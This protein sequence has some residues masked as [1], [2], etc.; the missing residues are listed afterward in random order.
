MKRNTNGFTIIELLVVIVVLGI[1]A[2][3]GVMSFSRVQ[4]NG[5][6]SQRY[7]KIKVIAEA[8]EKYYDKNGE[9]PG[10]VA[11]TQTP[12]IVTSNTLKDMDASAL[13]APN[14]TSGTNSFTCNEISIS[15]SG[16]FAFIGDGTGACSSGSACTNFTLKYV[17]EGSESIKTITSR[18]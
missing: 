2:T 1:L 17:E 18:R 6:D 15:D 3:I 7:Y 4:A 5:R 12:D 14:S 16:S 13:T 8:L 11:M 10:C 9:Y